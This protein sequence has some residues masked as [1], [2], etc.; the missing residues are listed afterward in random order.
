MPASW[1]QNYFNT[2][3][4]PNTFESRNVI[5]YNLIIFTKIF[6]SKI[7]RKIKTF[8]LNRKSNILGLVLKKN[9]RI[10]V[11]SSFYKSSVFKMFSVHKKTQSRRFQIYFS[12]VVGLK[13]SESRIVNFSLNYDTS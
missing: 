4:T 2:T 7:G 5:R 11:T 3:Q 8:N 9:S 13:I 10:L 12:G 1:L 6:Q